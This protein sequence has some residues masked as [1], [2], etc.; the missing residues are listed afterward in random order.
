MKKNPKVELC[1]CTPAGPAMRMMRVAGRVEFLEDASFEERL[2]RERPWV[3]DLMKNAPKESRVAVF[4]VPHGEAWFWTVAANL[5]EH[6]VP[7]IRF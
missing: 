7:R 5:R 3:R 1:F 2:Y 6:E 4:R